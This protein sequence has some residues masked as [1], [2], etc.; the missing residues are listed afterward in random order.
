MVLNNPMPDFYII[1]LKTMSAYIAYTTIMIFF[2][3]LAELRK[4]T[5]KQ[6]EVIQF[7]QQKLFSSRI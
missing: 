6:V 4:Q 2:T 5:T 1:N 3:N 7:L